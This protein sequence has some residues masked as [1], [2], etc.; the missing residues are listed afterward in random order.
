VPDA[1]QARL[2]DPFV[3][4]KPTGK[5]LGLALAAKIVADHGGAIEFESVPGRTV[6]TVLLPAAVET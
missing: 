5:G 6:F 1:L 4:S 3:T 2:F